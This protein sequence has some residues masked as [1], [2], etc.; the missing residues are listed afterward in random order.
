MDIVLHGHDDTFDV[1]PKSDIAV[2]GGDT[3]VLFARHDC[4]IDIVT[5]NQ[6]SHKTR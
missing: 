1:E 4:V 2:H 3:L 6:K 5:R